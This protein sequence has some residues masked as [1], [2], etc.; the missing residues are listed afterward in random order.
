MAIRGFRGRVQPRGLG[1]ERE[2]FVR[3]H[4]VKPSCQDLKD[5]LG[6]ATLK[7]GSTVLDLVK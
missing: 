6:V 5:F 3:G 2:G 1:K 7:E 4:D